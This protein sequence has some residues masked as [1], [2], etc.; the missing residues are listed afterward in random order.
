MAGCR[1]RR[2]FLVVRLLDSLLDRAF[3]G[4][5]ILPL[6][7]LILLPWTTSLYVVGYVIGDG[8]APWGILGAIIGV[9]MDV[10][11][12]AGSATMGKKRMA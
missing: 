2:R 7:G 12:H 3:N 1:R 4:G 5:W 6:A 10:A 9:F 8:A 11:L